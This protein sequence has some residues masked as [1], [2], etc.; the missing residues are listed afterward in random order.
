M[1]IAVIATPFGRRPMSLAMLANQVATRNIKTGST[2]NKWKLFRALCEAKPMLGVTDRGLALLN[3]LLSFYPN[4][5]LTDEDSL[6]VFPSNV[7]LSLRAHGMAEQTIRRHLSALVKSGLLVRK[8]SPNGKR[9]AHKARSGEIR[10]AFGFSLA[11]L[12]ARAD[13]IER[14]AAQVVAE[15]SH[16][17]RLKERLTLCRR[18][19]TKLVETAKH[20]AIN[21]D[22]ATVIFHLHDLLDLLPRQPKL[23]DLEAALQTMEALREDVINQ[24]ETQ[25]KVRNESANHHQNERHIQ[26][27]DS[28]SHFEY[29]RIEPTERHASADLLKSANSSPITAPTDGPRSGQRSQE[30]L[31][32]SKSNTLELVLKACPQI[33]SY[34]PGAK[35]SN[36]HDLTS[37]AF[38]VATMLGIDR[39]T[40]HHACSLMGPE[41][42]ATVVACIL[43]RAEQIASPGAYLRDLSRRAEK[44]GFIP[45]PM[46][47]ALLRAN[48]LAHHAKTTPVPHDI[49]G[50][51]QGHSGPTQN[52]AKGR[53]P[54]PAPAFRWG[55]HQRK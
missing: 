47:M 11:P 31:P 5:D 36:S 24:L 25:L 38:I 28:E 12:L 42:A 39:L 33:A 22:W 4:N 1:D 40:Y 44:G 26:R 7:Q 55:Q 17:Q 41:N 49:S 52:G 43:E 51:N 20:E 10:D 8:D 15:R 37:A 2:V 19:I 13:E 16:L 32:R 45:R 18:D 14:L 6:V 46:L 21:G 34:A 50:K 53:A 48:G 35:I 23:A 29:E 3:A 9:Y 30:S 54:N 27:S